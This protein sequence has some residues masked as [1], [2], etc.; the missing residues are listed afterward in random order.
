MVNIKGYL[1]S[2]FAK[3]FLSIF[4][5]FYLIISLIYLV[6]ISA[7]TA[8]IQLSFIELL[9]L[10]SYSVSDILFYTLPLSFVA[11]AASTLAKL[12]QDNE[13][14]ALYALGLKAGHAL[15]GLWILALLFSLLLLTISFLAM[16]LSKQFYKSFKVS[17]K[18]EAKLNIAA[19]KLGQKFGDY[20]IYVKK[21][22]NGKFKDL[23]I[24]NRTDK[25]KEQFF[26]SKRGE[27]NHT[28][29]TSSLLLEK[30]FGY[31]YSKES[32]QQVEYRS[33]EVFDTSE[34]SNFHFQNI[35]D[36]WMQMRTN[37][38]ILH[39]TLF[40]ILASLIPLLSLYLV[41]AFT[42]INPRYQTNH[43]FLVTFATAL[44]LYMTAST[45][46]KYGTVA[47]LIAAI[48]SIFLLGRWLFGLR[49]ARYF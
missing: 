10:Y 47:W 19:G 46:E 9:K 8:Q 42:M 6:K 26:A 32:L 45:L 16:P 28:D 30:G 13:L 22:E 24:Y 43:A 25:N 4:L 34:R 12:S 38:R 33:L 41:A 14:I 29:H 39:R 36:Y 5:P 48:L 17:K 31:T 37:P 7:L 11:A 2:N 3:T 44:L 1:S 20:Y 27:I 15:K 49:V 35:I 21:E 23:V 18:N 40:F